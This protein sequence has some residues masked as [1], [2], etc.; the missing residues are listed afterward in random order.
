MYRFELIKNYYINMY[1]YV[2]MQYINSLLFIEMNI[3]A[4]AHY[5]YGW[6]C[7]ALLIHV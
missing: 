7:V 5:G 1:Q 2:N 3:S 4:N 6:Q